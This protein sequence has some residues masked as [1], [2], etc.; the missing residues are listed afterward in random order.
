VLI[1]DALVV[2]GEDFGHLRTDQPSNVVREAGERPRA[3]LV[4]VDCP[5]LVSLLRP[6]G[7]EPEIGA[8]VHDRWTVGQADLPEVVN[9]LAEHLIV[10]ALGIRIVLV[11]RRQI[12]GTNRYPHHFAHRQG[13]MPESGY[14]H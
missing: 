8:D 5:R 2:E 3:R 13:A 4:A 6:D 10:D 7:V 12:E 9:A 11:D 1:P 14:K